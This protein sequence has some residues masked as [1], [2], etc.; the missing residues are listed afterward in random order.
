MHSSLT[1]FFII[2]PSASFQQDWRTN[3]HIFVYQISIYRKTPIQYIQWP[4]SQRLSSFIADI[5]EQLHRVVYQL[6]KIV[7][8][9]TGIIHSKNNPFI[10][11]DQLNNI[12]FSF[13]WATQSNLW[14]FESFACMQDH[15]YCQNLHI[16]VIWCSG[17]LLSS[18][19]R[20]EIEVLLLKK[21]CHFVCYR[22][23]L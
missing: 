20:V 14:T 22:C 9:H 23:Q 7:L 21:L 12:A 4:I 15:H 16:F 10:S 1:W 17:I 8:Y 19:F 18:F 6:T 5:H 13:Q 11:F 3:W 2:C